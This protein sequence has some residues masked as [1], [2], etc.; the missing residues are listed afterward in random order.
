MSS[1][2]SR[3][4]TMKF[5]NQQFKQGAQDTMSL[6]DKLKASLNFGG[7]FVSGAV[8]GL[9]TISGVLNKIGLSTPFAPLISG[10]NKALDIVG[11]V[12]ARIGGK[13]PF[14]SASTGAGELAAA[15]DKTS[16]TM[17][18]LEGGIT[19]V[20]KKFMAMSTIGITALS[21]ITNKM[22]NS[23][24]AF[25]KSFTTDPIKAGFQEYELKM[26]SIQT[27]L[28]NTAKDGTKLSDVNKALNQ[29]NHYADKTIYNFGDMTKNI[30]LFTNAG[31]KL[32]ESTSMIKGFSNE[33]AASGASAEQAAHAAQQLS[34][35]LSAGTIHAMDWFSLINAGM[36]NQ[37]MKDGLIGI[38][39]AMGTFDGKTVDATSAGKDFKGSL[40]QGWLTADVMSNYL[41]IMAGDMDATK[42][43]ALGLSDTM[44]KTLTKQQKTAEAA[45]TKVRT[46]TQLVGTIRESVGST[47]GQ[48]FGTVIG[49]FNSASKLFTTVNNTLGGMIGKVGNQRA[50]MFK[51]WAKFGGRDAA[52]DGL[53]AAWHDLL[54]LMTPIHDAFRDIFPA[55]TGKRLADMTKS[56]RDFM[57][58]LKPS[59]ATVD[60]LYHTFKGVFAIFD[61]VKQVIGAVAHEFGRL[62]G[63]IGNGSGGFLKFTGGLGDA[64]VQFDQFLKKSGAL[65]TIFDAIGNAVMVPIKIIAGFAH[66][67]GALFTGFDEGAAKAVT[68]AVDQFGKRLSPLESAGQHVLGFLKSLGNLFGKVGEVIGGALANVGDVIAA[69]FTPESFS[70]SLDVINTGLL[71][72][73]V[74]LIHN[75]FTKGVN[76]DLTGGLFDGV[77]ETLGAATGALKN[78]QTS[79]KADIL[80]KIAIALGILTASL[81]VLAMIDGKK[82]QKA[83]TAM[84]VGFAVLIGAMV[85]LM[86]ALGA[87]GLVQMYVISS[88]LTKLA[89]SM[90][91][92]SVALRILAN[93][94]FGDM[95]RGLVGMAAMLFIVQKAMIPLAAS[96]K[97][98]SRAATSLIL[99]GVALNILAVALKIFATMS[100][101]EMLKGLAGIAGVLLVLSGALKIMPDMKAEGIG[102]V[103]LAAAM[104]ILAIALKIF[105]TMSWEE[106]AKGLIMLGGALGLIAAGINLMPK[107]MMLQAAGLVLISGALLVMSAALK[108]FGSMSWEEIAKGLVMLAGALIIL[109]AGVQAIGI[110]GTIGA[111]GLAIIAASLALLAPVLLTFGAMDWMNILKSL[112]MLAGVFVILGLAGAILAPIVP[113]IVALGLAMV[114]MGAG[115]ALAGVG[116]LA[117]ATAFAEIVA[118]GTAGVQILAQMIGEFIS[119]I[120]EFMKAFAQGIAEFV[121]TI[122]A[123]GPAMVT[124]MARIVGNMLD[125]IIRNVPKMARAFL[126]M[127]NAALKVIVTASPKIANAGLTLIVRF[128]EAIDSHIGRIVDLAA[129]IIVKFLNGIARNLSKIIQSGVNLIIK[130]I[131]GVT[132]AIDNNSERIGRAG[133]NLGLALIRGMAN[134]IKGSAGAIKDAAMDA[135][136]DAWNSVK[137]FFKI[138]SPSKLMRDT[139]GRWIPAGVAVGIRDHA[140]EPVQQIDRMGRT[141]LDTLKT[142]MKGVNDAF[143]MST[144]LNPTI[145]PVLDLSQMTKDANDM[146]SI[147]ATNP[148]AASVSYGQASDISNETQAAQEAAAASASDSAPRGDI[149]IEQN[150]YSPKPLDSVEIYRNTKSIISLTEEALNA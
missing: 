12:F 63:A 140:H 59:K 34:Q 61:I 17:S 144:D 33:A 130:F 106:M 98:M 49:D 119:S 126:T 110:M 100:W 109:A 50:K 52:I 96:S 107:T 91:I 27:I 37:N 28:A 104:N 131:E 54:K 71:A 95:V 77:T 72:G 20:S 48:I 143:T 68:G 30:G 103:L 136:K 6:L 1:V 44:V 41:K 32:E 123:N 82:L 93:I 150:N 135:A 101:S 113:V 13:N 134:G 43:K 115:L 4:V 29:L 42:M 124:A 64:I 22:V 70:K 73:I 79:L 127:L 11:G 25:A 14:E 58:E 75:F 76:I 40:E 60:G 69:A 94:K 26:G 66:L 88:A 86:K 118:A 141:A 67:I 10:A 125:A 24:L 7:Q 102:L 3:I 92:L 15:A 149:K 2:D 105:A 117:F 55:M 38:A 114:L 120:P 56:F 18:T 53:V 116:A 111:V 65:T 138:G 5:D 89:L 133:A 36:G 87:V 85:S 21:N 57:R 51:D 129:S 148:V 97:G 90:L 122:A 39:D 31:L 137:D 142:T 80:M 132:K 112:T 147:L 83:L 74:L 9:G 47:Y 121:K 146:S 78:M 46:W 23:G 19:G 35:G 8:R 62:F 145:T 108:N 81:V 45:A 99:L 139:I 128:L 84:S 16:G